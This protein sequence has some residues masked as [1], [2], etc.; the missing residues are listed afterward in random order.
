MGRSKHQRHI[1]LLIAIRTFGWEIEVVWSPS[2]RMSGAG[3]V[4]WTGIWPRFACAGFPEATYIAPPFK[5]AGLIHFLLKES[6][7][8]QLKE[9]V[10]WKEMSQ[11][12]HEL[13][14]ARWVEQKRRQNECD[15]K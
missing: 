10:G 3:C 12:V 6:G 7:G 14:N 15:G 2:L 4:D 5:Q 11:F 9:C 8:K 13:K 1:S